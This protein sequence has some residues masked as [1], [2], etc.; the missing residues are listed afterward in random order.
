QFRGL[1]VKNAVTLFVAG[2]EAGLFQPD[3]HR[4]ANVAILWPE[5]LKLRPALAVEF[6]NARDGPLRTSLP[7]L[8]DHYRAR[9]DAIAIVKAALLGGDNRVGITRR[10]QSAGLWGMGGIGKTTLSAA[11]VK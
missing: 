11:V 3:E 5:R 1:A 6:P 2:I 8:P 7:D 9:A 4:S 10:A